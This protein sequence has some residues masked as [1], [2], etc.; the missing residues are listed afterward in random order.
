MDYDAKRRLLYV[1]MKNGKLATLTIYRG[2]N[3]YAWS[4]QET[5][6]MF[7]AVS[8][9][10]EDVYAMVERNGNYS[11]EVFDWRLNVDAGS[12]KYAEA[13]RK[14]WDG[15]EHLDGR[16]ISVVADG[17]VLESIRVENGRI[18]LPKLA[19]SIQAGIPYVH[20]VEPLPPSI[21]GVGSSIGRRCRPVRI[22][23]RVVNTCNVKVDTGYGLVD[24]PLERFG[25]RRTD[26]TPKGL[27]GEVTVRASGWRKGSG[28]ALWRVSQDTPLPFNLLSVTCEIG[29]GD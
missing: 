5:A 12:T 10:G 7:I 28:L 15:F 13:L 4:K 23:F 14:E 27:T 9:A 18:D 21:P 22:T 24:I 19:N 25:E 16:T 1:V 29:V 8:V 11:I 17:T 2:E 26:G 6:G 20:T 3:V